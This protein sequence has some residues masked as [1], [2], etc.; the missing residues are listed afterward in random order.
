MSNERPEPTNFHVYRPVLRASTALPIVPDSF[1]TPTPAD[2]AAAQAQLSARAQALTNAPLL[3][4]AQREADMKAKLDRWPETR[5]RIKFTDGLQLE[6][7]FPSTNKIRSIY[8]FVR[9]CLREDIKSIK[10][11]LYQP[12]KHDLKVSDL[13]VRDLSLAQLQLAPSSLLLLRFDDQSL[14]HGSVPA[15]LD[16]CILNHAVDLPL[17]PPIDDK[18]EF[19]LE[20]S[21]STTSNASSSKNAIA[22]V[23][24]WLK[25]NQKK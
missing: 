8:A 4:R 15:P 21:S 14:N 3:V 1:F 17:P 18:G 24:K 20:K 19:S 9:G 2:L 13:K 22:K 11:I 6:K 10:F 16:P 7:V 5:I 12:P 23:P 25:F